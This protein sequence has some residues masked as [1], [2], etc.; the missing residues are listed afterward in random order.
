VKGAD[1]LLEAAA[2]CGDIPRFKLVL[3]G[4]VR[5]DRVAQLASRPELAG[6]VLLAGYRD[7]AA[8]L[9]AAADLFVMPSRAEALSVALLEAMSRGICPVVSD[10]GGMKEGVR[11]GVDGL[12][13]PRENPAALAQALQDLAASPDVAARYGA[14]ARERVADTFSP[15][16][17]AERMAAIYGRLVAA[18]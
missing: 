7:D 8:Q 14:N 6:R 9:M 3:V 2:R 15:L 4:E 11:N 13:V 1:V 12:V 18:A 10:A 17:V 16:R 5:D